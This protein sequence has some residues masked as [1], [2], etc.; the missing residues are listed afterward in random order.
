MPNHWDRLLDCGIPTETCIILCFY[1][2]PEII[3]A[4]IDSMKGG[5]HD[6]DSMQP[7][8]ETSPC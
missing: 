7:E 3:E 4:V 5:D 6:V 8:P 1:F 2:S